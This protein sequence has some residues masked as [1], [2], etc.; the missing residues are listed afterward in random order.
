MNGLPP[1]LA[2]FVLAEQQA[3]NRGMNQLGMATGLLG[4]QGQLQQQ[5][6]Q[7]QALQDKQLQQQRLTDFAS[8]LPDADRQRFMVD[9]AGYLKEANRRIVASPGQQIFGPNGS[10]IA[11]VPERPTFQNVPVQGQPGV[12]Q[13]MWIRPGEANGVTVGAPKLPEILNPAVQDARTKIAQAGRSVNNISLSTEKKYGEQ[14]AS[15]VAQSDVAMRDA[16]IKAP[17]LADRSN[18]IRQVLMENPITGTGAELRLQFAKAA[19]LAGLTNSDAPE[20]TE[21]LA[22]SLSQNTLD[23]IKAS[24]LGSGSGFSNADRDF[25]EKA[26]G[27]KITMEKESLNRLAEL[28]HRAALKAAERWNTRAKQ[29]PP[30]ALSGTGINSDP[31]NVS[32]LYQGRR[33]SDSS[34]GQF[35]VLGRE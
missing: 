28:S 23:A 11:S 7:Q 22:A 30:D 32:P 6:M 27:G 12:T 21:I 10:P 29:I 35:R 33:A 1:G 13:G 4:L 19:K 14:F 31:I 26:A 5:A 16:A 3:N 25:L 2:G 24:G 20:N 15:Q 9:P 18:R 8:T 17:E 34:A